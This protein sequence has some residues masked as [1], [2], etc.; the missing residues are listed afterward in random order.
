MMNVK[1]KNRIEKVTKPYLKGK[2]FDRTTLS[3]ALKFFFGTLGMAL[4]FLI[5]C[6]VMNFDAKWLDVTVN[7]GIVAGVYL[8]FAQYG[9]NAGADAVNQGEIMYSRQEKGRPVADWELSMCFHPMKGFIAGLIGAMPLVICSIIFACIAKRQLTNLGAL[10]AWVGSM[11]GR[12]EL[13]GALAY[14]HEGG[15][16]S[17]EAVLR[18]IIR[19][20]VMPFVNIV[21]ASDND[22][23]LLLERV[24]PVLNLIPAFVYG[25][26]YLMG[27]NVRT[28][29][30]TNIAQGQKKARKKQAK[31]RRARLQRG[32]EQLN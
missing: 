11:E 9:V 5:L 1:K 3:T 10:P 13:G 21:G 2:A 7:L 28:S 32:P 18:V 31:E 26:G 19:M 20:S 17:L 8:F 24:S 29:V 12:Q 16:L 25:A 27:V 22:A 6:V 4:V 30:H 14:Y 15:S 23:M